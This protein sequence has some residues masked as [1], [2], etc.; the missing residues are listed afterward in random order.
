MGAPG[1]IF[2]DMVMDDRAIQCLHDSIDEPRFTC[3]IFM[4]RSIR[5]LMRRISAVSRSPL[6]LAVGGRVEIESQ[7]SA[8]N[9]KT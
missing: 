5:K 4:F 1:F 7:V 6:A 2:R 9:S 3:M 8:R